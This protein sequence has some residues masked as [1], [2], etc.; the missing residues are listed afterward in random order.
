MIMEWLSSHSAAITAV[1]SSLTLLVWL[2]YAQLLYLNFRR[3]RQ[4]KII[5]NR[6]GGKSL[7]ARCVIS[8][9]SSEPIFI[10]HIIAILHT[11]SERYAVSLIDVDENEASENCQ[12]AETTRQGPM[13]S[14]SFNHIGTFEEIIG[15]IAK[16]HGLATDKGPLPSEVTMMA[17]ELR[18]VAVYGSEDAPVGALRKFELSTDETGC[19]LTPT[20]FVTRRYASPFRRRRV[21]QWIREMND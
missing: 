10:E 6:G 5:I 13:L 21:R 15:R 3:Q 9:M 14:G 18:L 4:P 8:N 12:L 17:I 16:F 1:T 19:Y 20:T 7:N 2:F 11:D